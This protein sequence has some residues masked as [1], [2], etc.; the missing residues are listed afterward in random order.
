[1]NG[2]SWLFAVALC[3]A[4]A[5]HPQNTVPADPC[6]GMP[7]DATAATHFFIRISQS[8]WGTGYIDDRVWRPKGMHRKTFE[9]LEN[10]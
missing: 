9:R 3:S 1:M 8:A 4:T 10:R 2:W 6:H 7:K 5:T